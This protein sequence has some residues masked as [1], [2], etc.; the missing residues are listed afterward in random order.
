[1]K[2]TLLFSILFASLTSLAQYKDS[3][4]TFRK[5][6]KTYQKS[7]DFAFIPSGSYQRVENDQNYMQ[8]DVVGFYVRAHSV[9][10]DSFFMGKFEISNEKYLEFVNDKIE[11]DSILGTSF[12]P[13]TLVWRRPEGWGEKYTEYYLR[14]PAYQ[15]FPVVGVSYTQAKAY[16]EWLTEKYNT[17][18]KRVFKHVRFRIPTEEEWE[19][20][21]KGGLSYS[22]LPWGSSSTLDHEGKP[23]ANFRAVSQLSVYRDSAVVEYQGIT[24]KRPVYLSNGM[25]EWENVA[26]NRYYADLTEP[27]DAHNPNGYGLYNMAGNVE[28][29]VDAYPFSAFYTFSY[30]V[31]DYTKTGR[32][33]GVTKGGSWADTGYYLLGQVRQFYTNEQSS[34][35]ETGFRLVMEV[36]DF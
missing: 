15:N 3:L 2:H 32:T 8:K 7:S 30:T 17:D 25:R 23:R 36:L 35:A 1:M 29:M 16:A 27:V 13:D 31:D 11:E 34:S 19:Y 12:L 10:I 4:K 22:Y 24:K 18:E 33:W 28:E 26:R 20:A 14:H 6:T 5:L 21:Y 9:S